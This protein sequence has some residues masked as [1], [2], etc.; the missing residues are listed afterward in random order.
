MLKTLSQIFD[1][2]DSD[3]NGEI[4]ALRIDV[5]KIDMG[6]LNILKPLLLEMEQG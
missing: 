2:L 5:S 1:L 4:D 6:T 3:Q